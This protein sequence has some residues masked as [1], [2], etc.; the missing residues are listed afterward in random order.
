MAIIFCSRLKIALSYKYYESRLVRKRS[1][2][3]EPSNIGFLDSCINYVYTVQQE[4]VKMFVVQIVSGKV[5]VSLRIIIIG[6]WP[7][8]ERFGQA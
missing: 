4:H 5:T 2:C 8:Y 7:F 6:K 1:K 3:T